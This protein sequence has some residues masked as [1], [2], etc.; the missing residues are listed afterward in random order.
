[1]KARQL[2]ALTVIVLLGIV[3]TFGQTWTQTS[4]PTDHWWSIAS[5]AD[6]DKLAAVVTGANGGNIW[7]SQVTPSPQL[8]LAPSTTNLTLAWTIPSTNFVL[9]QNADLTA[10]NWSTVTDPP[11]LNLTNLQNQVALP[12]P[13]SNAFFRLRT[14]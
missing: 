9:E 1:M 10:G 3:S 8:N 7:T 13:A 11:V 5:S 14:P 2:F 4:A 12:L 6:G